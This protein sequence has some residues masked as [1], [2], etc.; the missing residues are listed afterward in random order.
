ML[1]CKKVCSSKDQWSRKHSQTKTCIA[2][3]CHYERILG[4]NF[5]QNICSWSKWDTFSFS[6]N[7]CALVHDEELR[8]L[9]PQ[10]DLSEKLSQSSN[11]TMIYPFLSGTCCMTNFHFPTNTSLHW[12]HFLRGSLSVTEWC[13]SRWVQILQH[14]C[15]SV[16][17]PASQK[18]LLPQIVDL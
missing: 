13:V 6:H 15:K 3:C 16:R 10:Y 1:S 18:C 2:I 14:I 11:S 5:F 8:R 4:R 7:C 17:F 9:S 12:S